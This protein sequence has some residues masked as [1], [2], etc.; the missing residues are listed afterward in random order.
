MTR[1]K[2]GDGSVVIAVWREDARIEIMRARERGRDFESFF[3]HTAR[4]GHIAFC[5]R[6]R[7][8]FTQPSGLFGSIR[9]ISWNAASAP[10]RSP[11][12]SKP[13]P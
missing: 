9:V 3:E 8:M 13:M 10:V 7:P 5:T 2:C 12:K 6:T 11:C 4:A 1:R